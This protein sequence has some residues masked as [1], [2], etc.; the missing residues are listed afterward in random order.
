M[1]EYFGDFTAGD[2]VYWTDTSAVNG[3]PVDM[4]GSP[5]VSVYKNSTTERAEGSAMTA[6]YDSRTGFYQILIDT[7]ASASFYA[8]GNNFDVVL[9]AGTLGGQTVVGQVIGSFSIENRSALLPTTKSRKLDVSAGGEAGLDWA[10][11]GSP[12]T[13]LALSGTTVATATNLTNA[14]SSGDLT[15][16]MKASVTTAATAATP[17]AAA[18]TGN[19]GGNV[20][21]SVGSVT[22]AVGSVTGAVGSVTGNVGGNVTGSVGSIASGGIAAASFASGAI[23]AAAIAADAIGASELASDAVAEIQSGLATASAL[24][25]AQ[26]DITAI[27]AKTDNLP[28]SPADE[29]LV[30]AATNAIMSRIGAPAGASIA[31]DIAEVEAE[32]DDIAAVK[33]KTDNLPASPAAVSDIPTAAENADKLLGRNIAGGSDGGRMVK[34]ALR[35]LR[36][37]WAVL[38][39]TLTVYAEDDTTTAWTSTVGTDSAA[40]PIVS[41]DPA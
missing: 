25:S 20:V 41:N 15:A 21:G 9:T 8:A 38:T 1:S 29:T 7:S 27:K 5:A 4:A 11:V 17:T 23:T 36:N 16:A 24:T 31:A 30:I 10:N 26:S 12:T 28:S 13:V 18:V 14:A 35:F 3:V 2:T 37:K 32:T 22:G 19:V 39:G 6:P 33:A 40:E 34:D